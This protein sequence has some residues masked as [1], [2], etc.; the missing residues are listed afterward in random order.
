MAD[1]SAIPSAR[2]SF[3]SM[4]REELAPRPGRL[5]G[6]IRT[7]V[8]CCAVTALAMVFQ[9][10]VAYDAAYVVFLISR[11]DVVATVVAGLVSLAA[12]TLAIALALL[13]SAFDAG[14]AALR[15]SLMAGV[16]MVAMYASR[17]F[18]IGPAAML[19]GFVLVKSQT[20]VDQVPDTEELVHGVL[21]LW[22]VVALPVG[23]VVLVELATGAW[24]AIRA[25]RSAL[26][27]LYALAD[28]LRRPGASDLRTRH[29]EAV[30]LV[31][32]TRRA[33]MVD[34]TVKGR[35]GSDLRLLEILGTLLSMEEVLPAPTPPIL[36][37]RL[38]DACDACANAYERGEP[39]APPAQLLP[40]GMSS[41]TAPTGVLPVVYAMAWAL[42]RLRA[43]LD[44][45]SRGLVEPPRDAPRPSMT[46]AG[47]RAHNLK[48]ALKSTLAVMSAYL[49]Y[50]GFA[51]PGISTAVTTCFFVSLGSLGESVQKLTLRISGALVG[52]L[53][54]GLCIA[55]LSPSMTDI[56]QLS[57]LI[58]AAAGVSAWIA[59]SSVRLSYMGMQ[60]AFA[61]LNGILQGYEPPSRFHVLFDRVFGIVLGNVLITVIFSTLW[62][63]SAKDRNKSEIDRACDELATFVGDGWRRTGA[64]LTVLEAV[65]KARRLAPFAKFEL[66][67]LPQAPGTEV[68]VTE[69]QRIVGFAFVAAELPGSAAVADRLRTENERAVQLL[70]AF[71]R[72]TDVGPGIAAGPGEAVAE[73]AV[74]SDRAAL[75]ASALLLSELEKAHGIAP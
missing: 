6:A 52:G 10:P 34:A 67:M 35:L 43:G 40:E 19:A 50:T 3:G 28:S 72:P 66:R 30:D 16:T 20:G 53:A 39:P 32:S 12:I 9:I 58:A 55:F 74:P 17:A 8:C 11:E 1:A 13:L 45:M 14:S 46:D 2:E 48:F 25:R 71:G 4:L 68:T 42:E 24:P 75:D 21:W 51:Y 73:G 49:I 59:A 18:K 60:I 63:T 38:A 37:G 36:R 5:A 64:R 33:A 57:L 47:E 70:R 31:A 44:A 7:A 61:F 26:G 29:A 62:P 54:A 56:G 65:D 27:L 41:A 22:V 69:L 23:I 15:L